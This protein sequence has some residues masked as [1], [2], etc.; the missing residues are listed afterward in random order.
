M[1]GDEIATIIAKNPNFYRTMH[2]NKIRYPGVTHY[3]NNSYRHGRFERF[4]RIVSRVQLAEPV[5]VNYGDANN[6]H[7]DDVSIV[8]FAHTEDTL[9]CT[10]P[11]PSVRTHRTM[12][13]RA[14]RR[15][16]FCSG[17]RKT[18]ILKRHRVLWA[19]Q[20]IS[21]EPLG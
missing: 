16:V 14:H 7:D 21:S 5:L 18:S 10:P 12:Y 3:Y 15:R 17:F 4:H 2:P 19:K 1:L 20:K 13:R 11:R 9:M 8:V 6:D